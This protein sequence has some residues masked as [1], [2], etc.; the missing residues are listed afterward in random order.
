MTDPVAFRAAALGLR[1]NIGSEMAACRAK[2][3]DVAQARQGIC[4]ALISAVA[5]LETLPR[6][7]E[8]EPPFV[9]RDEVIALLKEVSR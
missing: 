5:E 3:I 7:S 4:A 9:D 6:S 1:Q 2:Q 8:N